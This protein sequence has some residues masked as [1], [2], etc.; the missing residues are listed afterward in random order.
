[1]TSYLPAT[2]VVDV[3]SADTTS[4]DA[5]LDTYYIIDTAT[6]GVTI[7]LPDGASSDG[8]WVII[9]NAPA[10][11]FQ[12]GGS[13]AGNNVTIETSGSDDLVIAGSSSESLGPPTS[14]VTAACKR[15]FP[16]GNNSGTGAGEAG[17][18]GWDEN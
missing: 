3:D 18:T 12:V 7:T 9:Q 8:H 13:V 1:M 11:G 15:F 10:G 5:E 16:T 17:I 14:T 6:A 4:L 2:T